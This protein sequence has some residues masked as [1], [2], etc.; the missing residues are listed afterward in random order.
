MMTDTREC[1]VKKNWRRVGE[2]AGEALGVALCVSLSRG[3][4]AAAEVGGNLGRA[5]LTAALL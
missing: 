5:H 2:S 4:T 1:V 3:S